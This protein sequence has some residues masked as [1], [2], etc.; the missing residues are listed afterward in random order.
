MYDICMNCISTVPLAPIE[1]R[2]FS[3]AETHKFPEPC[4]SLLASSE[5]LGWQSL[6]VLDCRI[7]ADASA[8]LPGVTDHLILFQLD[9]TAKLKYRLGDLRGSKT[10]FPGQIT[11]VPGGFDIVGSTET[12]S[13]VIGVYIRASI[14]AQVFAQSCIED[15]AFLLPQVAIIDPVISGLIYGCAGARSW[16]C[17]K[18]QAYVDHFAWALAA[19]LSEKYSSCSG[20]QA[21]NN[22]RPLSASTLRIVDEYIRAHIAHDIGVTDIARAAGYNPTY[23]SRIFTR[24]LGIPPYRYLLNQRVQAVREA[25]PTKA[26]LA[27]IAVATGFCNQEH[28]TRAFRQFHGTSPSHYRR[29][30]RGAG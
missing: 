17:A 13:T 19:H 12:S 30:L 6:L 11:I 10:V 26:R 28:M 7:N 15:R 24:T 5:P 8:T 2:P 9:G 27:D 14:V 4:R 18:S 25:L 16:P 21:A 3:G 29:E 22:D 20:A 23:F 1:E